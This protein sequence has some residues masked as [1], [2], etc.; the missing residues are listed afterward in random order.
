MIAALLGAE[1][2]GFATA[3]LVHGRCMMMRVSHLNTC[4]MGIA[5]QDPELGKSS[6]ANPSSSRTA[7]FVAEDVRELMAQLGCRTMDEL[8][9]RR[10][11]CT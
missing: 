6:A 11:C 10:S 8:T 2:F 1:E 4:P 9:G 7:R 5:T 3:A